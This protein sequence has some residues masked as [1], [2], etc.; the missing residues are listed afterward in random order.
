MVVIT[1]T[2][3]H[4]GQICHS[5]QCFRMKQLE[6]GRYSV[7]AYGKYLEVEQNGDAITFYCEQEEF[8]SLWKSYFDLDTDYRIYMEEI[9]P[10]DTYLKQAATF[11]EG[12]RILRQEPWEMIISF[13][14]SQQNNI[15]RI[16]KCV[17]TICERY[18]TAKIS[19]NGVVYYEFPTMEQLSLATEEELRACNLGYRSKY[20]VKTT[21]SLLDGEVNLEALQKMEFQEAKKELLKLTGI[22][23]KV[24]ECICL[25]G[26]HHM[27][28]FPVDTHI[29][30]VLEKQYQGGFPFER[31]QGYAGILQQY[32]FYYDLLGGK[33]AGGE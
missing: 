2:Q 27:D 4:I 26:L 15:K 11:G 18:G 7:V 6:N 23:V 8:D 10:K 32:I 22:G 5:G 1:Q 3:F 16:R 24:A 19:E 28:G 25:F 9:D 20:I 12:I 14:I 31:Y 29:N 13:I 30:Q 21:K 33:E 17:E